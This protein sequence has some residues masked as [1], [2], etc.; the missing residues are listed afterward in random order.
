MRSDT[1]FCFCYN[2]VSDKNL[3]ACN[4][5]KQY[6]SQNKMQKTK[7]KIETGTEVVQLISISIWTQKHVPTW[8]HPL[9]TR[10]KHAPR[11]KKETSC[12]LVVGW[13]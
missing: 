5:I 2:T 10:K 9:G 13:S 4:A 7:I 1:V 6:P 8:S 11:M 3:Y 12:G